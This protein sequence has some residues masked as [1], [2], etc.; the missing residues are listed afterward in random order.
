MFLPLSNLL[1]KFFNFFSGPAWILGDVFMKKFYTVFDRDNNRV[2][3]APA[4]HTE[5]KKIY[6]NFFFFVYLFNLF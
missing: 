2:G 3:F 6:G 1:F 4:K 5:E